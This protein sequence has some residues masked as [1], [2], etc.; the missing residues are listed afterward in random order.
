MIR[1]TVTF[2]VSVPDDLPDSIWVTYIDLVGIE[3]NVD[4]E[5][6]GVAYAKINRSGL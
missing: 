5:I 3:H 6:D 2:T 4:I 1:R